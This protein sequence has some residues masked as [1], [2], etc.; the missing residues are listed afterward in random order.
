MKKTI[1]VLAGLVAAAVMA[2]TG[3]AAASPTAEEQMRGA[4]VSSVYNLDYPA[5][6]TADAAT[7]RREADDI[8]DRAAA[9]GLNAIFL[10]VRPTADALYDSDIFPWSHW[11]TGTQGTAPSGS[12]DPL[13][14]WVE[15]AHARGLELHA[16]I[17][18]YRVTRDKNWD[19]VTADNPAK[20]HPDWVVAY[21]DGNYYFDPG[22]PEVREL[23][24]QGAEE[25]VRKYDVD[26]IHLDDYFYPGAD[27]DDADTYARYGG[28]FTA[29]ADWRRDN[30]NQLVALLDS[31][32]HALDP[33]LSFG[34]SPAG[35]WANKT[36][37]ARG[38]DTRGGNESYVRA[39]ADSLAWIEA[40]TVD[41][42]IPQIYWEIG[43]SLADFATLTEWWRG[44]VR[45]SDVTL[46]IGLPSYR[47]GDADSAVWATTDPV[48]AQLEYLQ[49]CA[50]V[51]GAVHFRFG[52]LTDVSGFE[53][54]LTAWYAAHGAV[55]DDAGPDIDV[56]ENALPVQTMGFFGALTALV[57]ALIR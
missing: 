43:H 21:T 7:L 40:G 51:N 5:R 52:S 26:G 57:T 44:A 19:G 42:I 24:V 2:L 34:I 55:S 39:Y 6:A 41:Y 33:A 38:S 27:F 50:D 4:W 49:D 32:L 12:F 37:D 31:R 23:V 18:P 56:P 20:L 10:Q 48:F 25:I 15:G 11:L 13:A 8:L 1:R 3:A 35:V 14:Y 47:C 9:M 45:D 29:L 46:Y 28:G 22:L 36:T 30:V 54:R 17:N 16:W 53:S